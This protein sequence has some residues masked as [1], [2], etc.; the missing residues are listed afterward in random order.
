M[1]SQVNGGGP[2]FRRV[3]L[4]AASCLLLMIAGGCGG[5][6]A[7]PSLTS[8]APASGGP[9]TSAKIDVNMAGSVFR[10]ATATIV[11]GNT[12]VWNN[13]DSVTHTVTAR[14]KSFDSGDIA[15]GGTYA[16]TFQQAGTFE[17]FCGLHAAMIGKVIVQ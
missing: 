12:V 5:P 9:G 3:C 7:S 6:A 14:D 17:Y 13:N 2:V 16:Y 11:A 8:T 1:R 10:P 15:P 4:I